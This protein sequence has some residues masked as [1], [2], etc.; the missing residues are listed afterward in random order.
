MSYLVIIVY[1]YLV[2]TFVG[3]TRPSVAFFFMIPV[4]VFGALRG[5]SGKD[6]PLYLL[7]FNHAEISYSFLN[8][9]FLN[10]II[11]SARMLDKHNEALFLLFHA[12]IVCTLFSFV[13]TNEKN[14]AFTASIAPV[15]I[16]DG[17][18]NG[19]RI[20]FVYAFILMLGHRSKLI[21]VFLAFFS[22]ISAIVLMPIFIFIK[23]LIINPLIGLMIILVLVSL[24]G[25]IFEILSNY[26]FVLPDRY[27]SKLNQ[28]AELNH[29]GRFSGIVDVIII[30]CLLVLCIQPTG[31]SQ[32]V[33]LVIPFLISVVLF[34]SVSYSVAFIRINKLIMI[35]LFLYVPNFSTKSLLMLRALGLFYGVN[36]IRQ[37]FT[38]KGFLPYG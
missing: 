21:A 30:F 25:L 3:N 8:E 13:L 20:I 27:S 32:I 15:V 5:V 16:V 22:H 9:P 19:M 17:I 6:T 7:R 2:C 36:F 14:N 11:S 4:I 12:I 33:S 38:D 23:R 24:F 37:V 34:L 28:Y 1:L 29:A 26:F 35:S 18:T 31:K 10:F